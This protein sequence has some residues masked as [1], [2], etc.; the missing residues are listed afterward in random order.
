MVSLA[1]TTRSHL[2]GTRFFFSMLAWS[3]RIR[4]QLR[5]TPGC[6][7]FASIIMGPREFWTITV[8]DTRDKMMEFMRSGAH[9]DIM[10]E[11]SH[12]LDSFWL[13][14]WRPTDEEHGHWKGLTLAERKALPPS[15]PER[16][17]EQKAALEAV[18]KSMPRLRASS[19][20]SGAASFEYAPQQR[21][22]RQ[23]VAG[24]VGAS[25]RLEVPKLRQ[26]VAGWRDIREMRTALVANEDVLRCAFGI[27]RPRELYSLVVFRHERAWRDFQAS[28]LLQRLRERWPDGL[29]TMRWEADNEFGHWDGL[30][31]RRMK[32]GT[33]VLVPTAYRSMIKLAGEPELRKMQEARAGGPTNRAEARAARRRQARD[34]RVR[35]REQRRAQPPPDP[36]AVGELERKFKST[37]PAPGDEGEEGRGKAGSRP[38]RADGRA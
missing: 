14:R 22:A 8:W 3:L 23:L 11:F 5:E 7:R 31:L 15:A 25:V 26:T 19:S 27:S 21:R 18:W 2:R 38:G 13:M 34:D 28:D 35:R 24:G 4:K 1:V 30:R 9:E 36:E 6:V 32:L 10:W 33:K 17:A 20:P 12:W 37:L 16:T 29:W